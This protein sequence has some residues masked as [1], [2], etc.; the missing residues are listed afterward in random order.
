MFNGFPVSLP[1]TVFMAGIKVIP[2]PLL[3]TIM[4][5]NLNRFLDT[6]NHELL[7]G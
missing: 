6:T 7:T 3:V 2:Q 4:N 1:V 5:G